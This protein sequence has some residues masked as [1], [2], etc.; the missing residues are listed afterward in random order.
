MEA[1]KATL[2]LNFRVSEQQRSDRWVVKSDQIKSFVYGATQEEAHENFRQAVRQLVLTF[3]SIDSALT[4]IK[5]IGVE[6]E[7]ITPAE[8]SAGAISYNGRLKVAV[9]I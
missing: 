7:I 9:A 5:S 6:H 2:H 4:Y 3:P 1:E 8:V